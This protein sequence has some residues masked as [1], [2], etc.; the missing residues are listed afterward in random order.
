MRFM[1]F[2][3]LLIPVSLCGQTA[4]TWQ[5]FSIG[6]PALNVKLPGKPVAQSNS[7][8]QQV[9]GRIAKYEASYLKDDPAGLVVTIMH[10][11]YADGVP[12]DGNGAIEGTN[13]Q[14]E[15]SG[16]KVAIIS[17]TDTR[18][19]G[20]TAIKQRGKLIIGGQE[21]DYMDTVVIE[22]SMLWQVIVMVKANDPDLKQV[23]QKITDSLTF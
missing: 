1:I 5:D 6:V 22:G 9:A 3:A 14:W 12:A 21:H 20:K 10:V 17:T 11:V 23:L 4:H 16:M 2:L 7:L 18:I 13:G 8:P 15:R 19:S